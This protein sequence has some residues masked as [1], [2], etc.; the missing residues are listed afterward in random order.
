MPSRFP[1]PLL[2]AALCAVSLG[3]AQTGELLRRPAKNLADM[4]IEE[5]MNEP[6]TSVS[7]KETPLGE[8]PAAITVITPD[9]IRR[10]G[11]ASLPEALRLVPG[12]DVARIGANETAVSVRGF[13]NEFANKLLVLIDGRSV[14]SPSSAGVFWNAQDVVFED[15]ERIEVIRGPGA[16]LWGAN[17]VNGVINIITKSARE[18]QGALVV[19]ALGTEERPTTTARYGG[20]LAPNLYYRVYAKYFDRPSVKTSAG[21]DAGD[22]WHSLRSGFRVDYEPSAE[23]VFTLQG[24]AYQ[25]DVGKNISLFSLTPPFSQTASVLE[26]N[27]GDNVLGRWTHV[28]SETSRLTLQGYYDFLRQDVGSSI[29]RAETCDFDLVHQVA[30]G[31]RHDITWGAGYRDTL[32]KDTSTFGASWAHESHRLQLFNVFAQDEIALVPDRLQFTVGTKFEHNELSGEEW[33]PGVRLRWTP[34]ARQT[35]WAAASHAVRT[36][37]FLERDSR[38]NLAAGPGFLVSIFGNPEIGT[39]KLTAYELGYRVAP[40]KQLSFEASAFYDV[41]HQLI[42]NEPNPP[43]FEISPVPP[44]A[45]ISQT[46]RNSA[47][48]ETYGAELSV[49]WQATAAW[50]LAGSYAWL[51]SNLTS[52]PFVG[53]SSPGQQIQIR[54]NLD[55]PHHVELNGA[56]TYVGAIVTPLGQI[57][58]PIPAYVRLDLGLIFHPA[59]AMEV[60]VWGVNLLDRRHPE[61]T[62]PQSTTVAEMPRGITGKITW[63][64]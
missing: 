53:S 57:N 5:L 10:L 35:V 16:T 60:G 7:K 46:W 18:T 8:S 22:G 61:F 42:V 49:H 31:D 15:L 50:R 4:S 12:L 63:R 14:Y 1:T 51:H 2:A 41:Y 6:V 48:G 58:A 45:L 11:I 13:N 9:D 30:L 17:A 59:A 52:V 40:A 20:Q 33:E 36:P 37:S 26:H 29:D 19:T 47:Q 39:E 28:F 3:S 44:H 64:F 55:L 27:A 43:G 62:S 38:L 54:S 32:A 56:V 25:S 23:N 24:D 21:G 34:T